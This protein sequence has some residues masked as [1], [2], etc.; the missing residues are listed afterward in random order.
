MLKKYYPSAYCQ[1]VFEI[2]YQ[3]LYQ[4]GFKGLIF[5]IDNTLVHHGDGATKEIE[6]LFTTIQKMGFKTFLLTNNEQSRVE[7]FIQNIDTPYICDAD[8]PSPQN[9]LKAVHQLGLQKEGSAKRRS[10]LHRG[11]SF[12]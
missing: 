10:D 4:L 12:Y 5:D 3:K 8:K 2:N 1:S 7:D 9:Y 11:P 6:E